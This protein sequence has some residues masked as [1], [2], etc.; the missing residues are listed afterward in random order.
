ML[1]MDLKSL[2]GQ[3]ATSSQGFY[4]P[5]LEGR[6]PSQSCKSGHAHKQPRRIK[7]KETQVL[8]KCLY[9]I[10]KEQD[11]KFLFVPQFF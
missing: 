10:V 7:D 4:L 3:A 1:S 2:Q 6:G 8:C 11:V 9:F 5:N